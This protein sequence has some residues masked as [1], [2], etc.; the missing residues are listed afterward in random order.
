MLEHNR[1]DQSM[2]YNSERNY[3]DKMKIK[4]KNLKNKTRHKQ[5]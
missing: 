1:F 5:F 3:K 2:D 4:E